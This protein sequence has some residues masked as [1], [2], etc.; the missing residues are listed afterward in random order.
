[1]PGHLY[2][3]NCKSKYNNVPRTIPRMDA[4]QFLTQSVNRYH[5]QRHQANNN[6][7]EVQ[8]IEQ[9][10]HSLTV[11]Q[12]RAVT[13]AIVSELPTYLRAENSI[14]RPRIMKEA[15]VKQVEVATPIQS[16]IKNLVIVSFIA[17]VLV[18]PLLF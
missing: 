7:G 14:F 9:R 4:G 6:I 12:N 1:M 10:N 5:I 18:T 16:Y 17:G 13:P 3:N 8:P 15:V 11:A 2:R